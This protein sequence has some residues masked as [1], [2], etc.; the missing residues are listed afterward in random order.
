MYDKKIKETRNYILVTDKSID[1]TNPGKAYHIINKAYGVIECEVNMLPQ[2]LKYLQ[3]LEAGLAAMEDM[4]DE[5]SLFIPI[6]SK[7][8]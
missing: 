4:E 3:D 5:G 2:A 8:N 7:V 6:K 1:P